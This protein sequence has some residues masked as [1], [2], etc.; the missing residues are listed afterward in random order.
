MWL[1]SRE[2]TKILKYNT[3]KSNNSDEDKDLKQRRW[4]MA[5]FVSPMP[6]FNPDE[7]VGGNQAIQRRT[8]LADFSHC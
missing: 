1:A 8:W 3:F 2:K 6:S 4:L 7:K 5:S